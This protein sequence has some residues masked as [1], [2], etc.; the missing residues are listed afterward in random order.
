MANDPRPFI[1][2]GM[3]KYAWIRRLFEL[4]GQSCFDAIAVHPASLMM[5]DMFS[6]ADG[7]VLV[8]GP[9][10]SGTSDI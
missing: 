10:G 7:L 2:R 4:G 8:C 9:T 6:V 1:L 5:R 3:E